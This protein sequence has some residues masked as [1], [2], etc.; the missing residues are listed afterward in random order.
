MLDA[1][2]TKG[3]IRKAKTVGYNRVGPLCQNK[4]ERL[5][6]SYFKE[7]WF[8]IERVWVSVTQPQYITKARYYCFIVEFAPHFDAIN[9][10]VSPIP[11][12]ETVDT[13]SLLDFWIWRG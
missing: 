6:I 5:F 7:V 8:D 1:D 2:S 10:I 3:R 13:K 9:I 11:G 12:I 4:F